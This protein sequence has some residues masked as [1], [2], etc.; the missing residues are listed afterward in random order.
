M[1]LHE[2]CSSISALCGRMVS[3]LMCHVCAVCSVQCSNVRHEANSVHRICSS[4]VW[5]DGLGKESE[6]G[7]GGYTSKHS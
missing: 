7:G 1:H 5:E 4:I 6:A 2:I 3:D